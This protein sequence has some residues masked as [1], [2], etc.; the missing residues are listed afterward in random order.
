MK[1]MQNSVNHYH[2]KIQKAGDIEIAVAFF[3]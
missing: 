1:T 3:S 2:S